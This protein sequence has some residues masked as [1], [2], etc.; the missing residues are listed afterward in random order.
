[1]HFTWVYDGLHQ[2]ILWYLLF[3]RGFEV[4]AKWNEGKGLVRV[5]LCYSSALDK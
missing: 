1:M 5:L 4:N 3:L 2:N